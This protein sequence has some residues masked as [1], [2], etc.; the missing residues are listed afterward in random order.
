[1][2]NKTN[3]FFEKLKPFQKFPSCKH[4]FIKMKLF[5]ALY[6]LSS[7]FCPVSMLRCLDCTSESGQCNT[8]ISKECEAD[9]VC[10][11]GTL[12]IS[13]PGFNINS[14]TMS[15][16]CFSRRE[17]KLLSAAATGELY[18][19]NV[20]V[21]Q[22]SLFVASCE[23]DNCNNIPAPDL[24][25]NPNGLKCLTCD[26]HSDKVC[27]STVS[28]VRNQNQCV[29]IKGPLFLIES[30]MMLGCSSKSVC[31]KSDIY[32]F[33]KFECCSGNFCNRV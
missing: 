23:S 1:M 29:I 6:V 17:Q 20:G 32:N 25:N 2:R 33:P 31:E 5:L 7:S 30:E 24:D 21:A 28:C 13:I 19:A 10:A 27:N 15:R 9:H 3:T 4:L 8:T 11:S 18:S 14:T 16:G 12:S 22:V 26:N